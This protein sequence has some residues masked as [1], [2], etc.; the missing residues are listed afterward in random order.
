MIQPHRILGDVYALDRPASVDLLKLGDHLLERDIQP[1]FPDVGGERAADAPSEVQ[2]VVNDIRHTR[3]RLLHQGQDLLSAVVDAVPKHAGTA[4][5]RCNRILDVVGKNKEGSQVIGRKLGVAYLVEGNVRRSGNRL[6]VSARL[7]DAQLGT[8]VWAERYDRSVTDLFD[9]QD[10]IT[11]TIV[12]TLAGRIESDRAEMSLRKPPANLAAYDLFLK[13]VARFRSYDAQ[14]NDDA[15]RLLSQ[16]LEMDPQYAHAYSFLALASLANEGYAAASRSTRAFAVELAQK[17]VDLSPQDATC[18][19]LLGQA[20]L[21]DRNYALAENHAR[22]AVS[23]NPNDSDCL[24][25]LGYLLVQRGRA[26]EALA[27]MDQAIRLNPFHPVWYFVH[28][29]AAFFSLG[30][31]EDCLAA[32]GQLPSTPSWLFRLAAA[33]SKLGRGHEASDYGRLIL[34]QEPA[35]SVQDFMER[36]ILLERDEDRATLRDALLAAGLPA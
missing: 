26:A 32:M 29:A 36:S 8:T 7:V 11:G 22:R 16:S 10:D 21:Y 33:S 18:Q 12:S 27:F 28:L 13:G 4:R 3:D 31:Y 23:L 1:P 35:F 34:Q 30:R 9:V 19:R 25:S 2:D 17:A 24:M 20:L 15:V 6:R 5:N 14:A